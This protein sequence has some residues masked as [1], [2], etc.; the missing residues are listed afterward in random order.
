MRKQILISCKNELEIIQ[1]IFQE[2]QAVKR[3]QLADVAAL[4]LGGMKNK[5]NKKEGKKKM[6]CKGFYR[7]LYENI[8]QFHLTLFWTPI[9][10][11]L[12]KKLHYKL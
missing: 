11:D 4:G 3:R 8:P 10:T 6:S 5:Q 2:W 12:G 1:N 7:L 9:P